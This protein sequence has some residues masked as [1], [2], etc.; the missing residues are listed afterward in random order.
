MSNT[1]SNDL[2]ELHVSFSPQEHRLFS[3]YV[4]GKVK[5][6]SKS[7][8]L[9]RQVLEKLKGTKFNHWF[10][11]Q[12]AGKRKEISKALHQIGAYTKQY[13]IQNREDHNAAFESQINYSKVLLER[14]LM[15]KAAKIVAAL[16]AELLRQENWLLLIQVLDQERALTLSDLSQP[17]LMQQLA[18]LNLAKE[19]YLE[20]I[21]EE[22]E[23]QSLCDLL[24]PLLVQRG[25]L[26]A[27]NNEFVNHLLNREALAPKRT[28]KSARGQAFY[29]FFF[30]AYHY[31]QGD[32]TQAMEA[33]EARLRVFESN[34]GLIDGQP[35]VYLSSVNNYIVTANQGNHLDKVE[36]WVEKMKKISPRR[37][38]NF[39]P[40]DRFY[41]FERL[42]YNQL[43]L[44]M[45]RLHIDKALQYIPEIIAFVDSNAKR[46]TTYSK[47]ILYY[48]FAT[49][50]YYSGNKRKASTFA[51]N[52]I[53]SAPE[54]IRA[55]Y[56]SASYI[57][58]LVIA[59]EEQDPMLPHIVKQTLSYFQRKTEINPIERFI[60]QSLTSRRTLKDLQNKGGLERLRS[61]LDQVIQEQ[62]AGSS[63]LRYFDLRIWLE[64]RAE[65]K[66]MLAIMKRN[67]Q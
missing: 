9:T 53:L 12:Q 44:D 36:E 58:Q 57:L 67:A 10:N 33:S 50:Y 34:Q 2:I 60:Y 13:L 41:Y 19:H 31:I 16:K 8:K 7:G 38:K 52:I 21:A 39:S 5:T 11:S 1:L 29:Y 30:S 49:C 20:C 46:I 15:K 18:E 62:E 25:H 65:R 24:T 6:T 32:F 42:Y 66:S 17:D 59:L 51:A 47:I 56:I 45:K 43:E 40:K 54:H 4:L 63:L 35:R 61:A 28:F 22:H 14:G 55:D 26:D 3:R 37:I 27:K 64:A 48:H 23:I